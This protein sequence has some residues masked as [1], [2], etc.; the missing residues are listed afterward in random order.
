MVN[1]QFPRNRF[2]SENFLAIDRSVE[3]GCIVYNLPPIFRMLRLAH[4]LIGSGRP[5]L[6][7]VRINII[8]NFAMCSLFYRGCAPCL[9]AYGGVVFG[10]VGVS[11]LIRRP[12][13]SANHNY[14]TNFLFLLS[15][16]RE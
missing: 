1:F 6:L 5:I 16:N 11:C 13:I 15:G 12:Y 9:F 4:F 8:H 10:S 3:K 7:K 14:K 2:A